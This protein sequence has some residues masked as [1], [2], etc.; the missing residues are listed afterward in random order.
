MTR[1]MDHTE[2]PA[3]SA[4][5]TQADQNMQQ[6]LRYLHTVTRA[7][8]VAMLWLSASFGL[9][10]YHQVRQ[11]QRQVA[12]SK[13]LLADYQTNALPRINWFMSSLQTFSKTNPDFNPVLAKYNLLP[14]VSSSVSPVTPM[15]SLN[16]ALKK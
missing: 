6:E 3:P 7:L 14:P 8:L 16:P 2:L 13:R 12:E 4:A 10:L 5:T 11:M 1:L 9:Y 15:P